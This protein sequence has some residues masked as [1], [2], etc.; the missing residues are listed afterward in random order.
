MSFYDDI[1]LFDKPLM[2]LPLDEASGDFID[3]T[4]NGFDAAIF[5]TLQRAD[6]TYTV[7]GRAGCGIGARLSQAVGAGYAVVQNGMLP[8]HGMAD[9]TLEL[10]SGVKAGTNYPD[11]LSNICTLPGNGAVGSGNNTGYILGYSWRYVQAYGSSAYAGKGTSGGSNNQTSFLY[12]Y[13]HDDNAF[14][15]LFTSNVTPWYTGNSAGRPLIM[16]H[17][18]VRKTRITNNNRTELWA[19]GVI[20]PATGLGAIGRVD[21]GA[22]ALLRSNMDFGLGIFGRPTSK[23]TVVADGSYCTENYWASNIAIYDYALSDAQI[24]RHYQAGAGTL[25]ENRVAGTTLLD[26]VATGNFPVFVHRRDTGA[27]IGKTLSDGSGAFSCNVGT[28]SGQVYAVCFDTVSGV[29][30]PAQVFDLILPST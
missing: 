25:A 9:W 19:N 2:Y 26:G 30:H 5:G 21:T 29:R 24:L 22:S 3:R 8:L 27:L 14:G 23:M 10:W 15:Q 7:D 20:A 4:G 18:I 13:S 1:V 28:Y 16:R 17:L 12:A 11:A 6:N